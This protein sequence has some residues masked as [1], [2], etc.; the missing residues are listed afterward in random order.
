M[1]RNSKDD[2]DR[3]EH[4]LEG[5]GDVEFD[6]WYENASKNQ[7]DFADSLRHEIDEDNEDLRNEVHW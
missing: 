1:K 6:V 2:Y 4:F 7:R 3:F 5:M